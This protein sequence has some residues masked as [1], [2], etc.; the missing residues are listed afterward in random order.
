MNRK[1]LMP[2]RNDL[3]HFSRKTISFRSG[4][5]KAS[6]IKLFFRRHSCEIL[7][8]VV[9]DDEK[10]FTELGLGLKENFADLFLH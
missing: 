4:T 8:L 7:V 5:K 2:I 9:I 6:H 1:R 3:L 10:S